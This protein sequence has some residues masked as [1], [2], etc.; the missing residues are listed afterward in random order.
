MPHSH[1]KSAAKT[2]LAKGSHVIVVYWISHS[3][4]L[5]RL[6]F[7]YK[8]VFFCVAGRKVSVVDINNNNDDDDD[9]DE[10]YDGDND[11][12]I[13]IMGI[14]SGISTK[15]LFNHTMSNEL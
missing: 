14:C 15:W 7:C 4:S 12:V 13:T 10:D 8:N 5:T 11:D 1:V 2:S 9:D 3:G 6:L